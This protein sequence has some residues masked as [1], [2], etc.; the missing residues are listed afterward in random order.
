MIDGILIDMNEFNTTTVITKGKYEE[1]LTS[2]YLLTY[3]GNFSLNS[4]RLVVAA[5]MTER[6]YKK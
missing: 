6:G 4:F 2:F 5:A 3:R 1:I